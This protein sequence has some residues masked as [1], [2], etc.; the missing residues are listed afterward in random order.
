MTRG[1][2][3][4]AQYARPL[5]LGGAIARRRVRLN[6]A[7]MKAS[8]LPLN[9]GRSWRFAA[10]LVSPV[11]SSEAALDCRPVVAEASGG[12]VECGG[13]FDGEA[14]WERAEPGACSG[15]CGAP[16]EFGVVDWAG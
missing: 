14:R 6:P 9:V 11:A 2:S 3:T 1:S 13:L 8:V 16:G 10:R 4:S 15:E 7:V 12:V 5:R